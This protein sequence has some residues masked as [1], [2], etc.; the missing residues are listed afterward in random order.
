ML[1]I[2]SEGLQDVERLNAPR[3]RP[4]VQFYS[5]VL[6]R[7]TR[8]SRIWRRVEFD[9]LADFGR[10]AIVT[11]PVLGELITRAVLVVNLPTLPTVPVGVG[12]VAPVWSWTNSI[13]NALCS[14]MT[15]LIGSSTV[16]TLD[17]RLMEIL[18]EQEGAPEHFDSTN[19]LLGRFPAGFSPAVA[20][21]T[22]PPAPAV[23]PSVELIPPF[24]WN[25]GVGP[26]ALPIQAL[27]RDK[28]QIQVTFR[29]A[30]EC[31]Y[32]E[33]RVAS[34]PTVF[35]G[36][37]PLPTLASCPF[38]DASGA[39]VSGPGSRAPAAYHFVDAFWIVEYVN[40]EDREAAAFR[41]G[42]LHVP[43][44]QHLALPPQ[45]T[46]GTRQV[47]VP[48][49]PGGLI[50]DMTWVAQRVEAPTYNNYF[51][52]SRDLN[53]GSGSG[54]IW[55]PNARIPDW[56]YGDGYMRPAFVDRQSDPIAGATLWTQGTRRFEHEGPSIFRSL[57]P[58]LGSRRTPWVD[59]YIYRYDFGLW[60]TGGLDGEGG[61]DEYRGAANWDLIQQKELVLDMAPALG[62]G[63]TWSAPGVGAYTT[64]AAG[65]LGVLDPSVDGYRVVLAG[66]RPATD[67]S[68]NGFGAT[69]ECTVN[70]SRIRRI[71][72]F[73]RLLVRC[74]PN[75]SAAL[76]VECVGGNY[77]WLAV[78]AGGGVGSNDSG[79]RGGSA[80][81]NATEISFQGGNN[82]QTHDASGGLGGGGGGMAPLVP[83][84]GLP[85]GGIAF[86]TNSP[87]FVTSFLYNGGL[88]LGKRGGDGY[89]GGGSGAVAG[90]GGGSYISSYV[91][92]VTT[93]AN[94]GPAQAQV[95][96]LTRIPTP[97]PHMDIY[98]WLTRWNMMRIQG[99]R[100]V[101]MFSD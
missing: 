97:P 61:E 69:I 43:I 84:L 68:N 9:G 39:P 14:D 12:A 67:I 87:S 92:R 99:G 26:H 75:G 45:N 56:N 57:I 93:Y 10:T 46:A 64:Y 30:Q 79:N 41:L 94:G 66:A 1:R 35:Q 33:S 53:D 71:P 91:E 85:D 17:S 6:R 5:I 24:G 3:G 72:G 18:T 8:W 48:I 82:L 38:V 16:D 20:N 40:L 59:R 27:A 11:L 58:A 60:P 29:A 76:V 13:G 51:L 77:V 89:Y 50:R 28:V 55:W 52:F 4:S 65:V 98:V 88:T 22:I 42:D 54:D 86:P 95:A 37:G 96:P 23:G 70:M 101:V 31:V 81:T 32:T 47:R 100:G 80:A 34:N 49:K 15:F 62:W 73:L 21:A 19:S 74:V 25:R 44:L 36:P 83:G 90:G 63:F 2:V 78:A 7:R